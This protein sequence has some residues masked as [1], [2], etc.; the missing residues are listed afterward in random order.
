MVNR[1]FRAVI[2][3]NFKSVLEAVASPRTN[4]N[5]Y[6]VYALKN[7][8][9]LTA[10]SGMRIDL[11]WILSH[12]DIQGNEKADELAKLGVRNGT[13]MDIKFHIWA[14]RA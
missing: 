4:N 5:N 9:H 14:Y 7:K 2:F 12:K 8:L 11:A 6:L 1:G 3:T 13:R 10:S